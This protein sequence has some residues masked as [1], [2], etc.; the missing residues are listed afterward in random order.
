MSPWSACEGCRQEVASCR[1]SYTGEA[2][3]SSCEEIL[4]RVASYWGEIT[5]RQAGTVRS[6]AHLGWLLERIAAC[7]EAEAE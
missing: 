4:E 1:S 6:A 7:R 5:P 2:L 3:C